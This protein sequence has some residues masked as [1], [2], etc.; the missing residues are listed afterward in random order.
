MRLFLKFNLVFVVIFLIGLGNAAYISD[1]V[2]EQNAREEILQN[3]RLVLESALAASTYTSTQVKPLLE[4]QMKY[5]FL[6]QSV[7]AYSATEVFHG[8]SKKFPEYTY[9]EATINPTNPQ[10]RAIDWEAGIVEQFRSDSGLSEI[11]NER[12]T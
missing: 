12:A 9:K 2:L 1:R 5:A 6:P 4:T 8:L 11:V 10:N 7:P 3:A